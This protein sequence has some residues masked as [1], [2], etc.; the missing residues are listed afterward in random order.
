MAIEESSCHREQGE[1]HQRA[2]RKGEHHDGTALLRMRRPAE[3][4]RTASRHSTIAPSTDWSLGLMSI[5]VAN[6]S[7]CWPSNRGMV[8]SP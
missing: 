7:P 5:V 1:E 8:A 2:R 6:W 3:S 4:I